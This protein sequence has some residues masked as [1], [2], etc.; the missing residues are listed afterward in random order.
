MHRPNL[1]Q[2]D[3]LH[4]I[5]HL[6]VQ[7]GAKLVEFAYQKMT[8]RIVSNA[9]LALTTSPLL[10]L[11]FQTKKKFTQAGGKSAFEFGSARRAG[12]AGWRR[13]ARSFLPHAT[14]LFPFV[15]SV[16]NPNGKEQA[17]L[18]LRSTALA[19]TPLLHVAEERGR[20]HGKPGL[21]TINPEQARIGPF[22][23]GS[24]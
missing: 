16:P 14:A 21:R 24:E 9:S 13:A 4:S 19:P 22:G 1:V 2:G 23:R 18:P 20:R 5:L 17:D 8:L 3:R 12:G 15:L 7:K 11:L 10:A 6:R